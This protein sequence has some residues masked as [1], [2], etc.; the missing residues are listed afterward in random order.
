MNTEIRKGEKICIIMPAFNEENTIRDVIINFHNELQSAGIYVIDNNSNDNT[1]KIA[2][3][4]FPEIN[5][6]NK[7]GYLIFEKR[8][9]KANAVKRAFSDIDADI[10]VMVDTDSTYPPNELK[11]LLEPI[12]N[13]EAD[14]V[15]ADRQSKGI[16]RSQNKR[17]FH[18]FGNNLVKNLV[19]YLYG[20]ELQD[21]MSGYRALNK[22]FVK[23]FPSLSEE[24]EIETEMTLHALD[25]NFRIIEVPIKYRDRPH[26]SKSKLHTLK[27]GFK[28]L[29]TIF[30][31]FK[32]YKPLVF[33]GILSGIFF[34]LSAL[35]GIPVIYEYIQFRYIFK[36][37]SAILATGLM[38]LSLLFFAIALILDTI[39]RIQKFNYILKLQNFK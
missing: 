14:M 13:N 29:K 9:G 27:D 24:F 8:K 37:P 23:N 33:F 28:I 11:K 7:V 21:I 34:I 30:F 1:S 2:S 6:K 39:V 19:N 4:T 38:I 26:N 17:R 5:S 31:I 35:I 32:D 22:K 15:V 12:L 20:S 10:Y 18:V 3:E 16:Y 36:V 25:K